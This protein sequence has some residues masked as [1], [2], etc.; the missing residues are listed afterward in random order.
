MKDEI[1]F[2]GQLKA[3]MHWPWVLAGV[4]VLMA[5]VMFMID[6]RAGL[7]GI[8]FLVVYLGIVAVI[9][10]KSRKNLMTEMISF[11][12]SYG[13]IQKELLKDFLLP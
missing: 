8:A 4:W 9:Y 3:L 2:S 7:L 11:A 5:M 6:V 12:A 10:T 1:K 13:Q